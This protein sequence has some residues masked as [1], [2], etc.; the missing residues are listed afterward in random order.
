MKMRLV[1][2]YTYKPSECRLSVAFIALHKHY[3]LSTNIIKHTQIGI[4]KYGNR[5]AHGR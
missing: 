2:P 1:P 3:K 5:I 4:I